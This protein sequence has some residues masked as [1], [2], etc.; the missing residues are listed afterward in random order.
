MGLGVI[1]AFVGVKMLLAHTADKIDTL[2]S[3]GM[4]GL[5]LA[6]SVAASLLRPKRPVRCTGPSGPEVLRE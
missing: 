1:L 2:V 5:I 3:L 4:V 6:I